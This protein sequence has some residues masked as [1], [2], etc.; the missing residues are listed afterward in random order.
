MQHAAAAAVGSTKGAEEQQLQA[1]RDHLAEHLRSQ[2][3]LQ[4]GCLSRMTPATKGS[5]PM[6][7]RS[8]VLVTKLAGVHV[9]CRLAMAAAAATAIH[10]SAVAWDY[11][12]KIKGS[13]LCQVMT[14]QN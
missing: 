5:I 9:I 12:W 7:L 10:A 1:F 8:H 11:C 3:V 4:G 14:F 2:S 13:P 6:I